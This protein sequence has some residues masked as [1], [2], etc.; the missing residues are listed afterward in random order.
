[1]YIAGRHSG[2]VDYVARI[3][4]HIGSEFGRRWARQDCNLYNNARLID[5]DMVTMG[6]AFE[7]LMT[8]HP[9]NDM[10]LMPL[11]LLLNDVHAR[12]T[13]QRA[14]IRMLCDPVDNPNQLL[15]P[16]Y[17]SHFETVINSMTAR[18]MH[19][20][21]YV[22]ELF[23]LSV[24]THLRLSFPAIL[25]LALNEAVKASYIAAS[26]IPP[27][28]NYVPGSSSGLKV[29]KPPVPD[30]PLYARSPVIYRDV[31]SRRRTIINNRAAVL[32]IVCSLTT[33]LRRTAKYLY[34]NT[35]A[36]FTGV[37]N[38]GDRVHS[39]SD[40][41]LEST[42]PAPPSDPV[43]SWPD[44]FGG[45]TLPPHTTTV[46]DDPLAQWTIARAIIEALVNT[47]SLGG[48]K[49]SLLNTPLIALTQRLSARSLAL[50]TEPTAADPAKQ[51]YLGRNTVFYLSTHVTADTLAKHHITALADNLALLRELHPGVALD[52]RL[53]RLHDAFKPGG[54][55]AWVPVPLMSIAEWIQDLVGCVVVKAAPKPRPLPGEAQEVGWRSRLAM[56]ERYPHR[57]L[58]EPPWVDEKRVKVE[59]VGWRWLV[60]VTADGKKER[61]LLRPTWAQAVQSVEEEKEKVVVA[62]AEEQMQRGL[63]RPQMVE[64]VR[65]VEVC[66][67]GK[68]GGEG[69]A[70]KGEEERYWGGSDSGEERDWVENY[71]RVERDW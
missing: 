62:E 70:R 24:K 25:V 37:M 66:P 63:L 20:A 14:Q 18:S 64:V 51:K 50:L 65:L 3:A 33:L 4:R 29:R 39:I 16:E 35:D 38:L 26:I 59:E 69:G 30:M 1:M 67:Q 44:F 9:D 47:H 17:V 60:G 36:G 49:K 15:N 55:G 57:N 32:R 19:S 43:T 61:R 34:G 56:A 2:S 21:Q 10:R 68:G 58:V 45:T 53:Q 31:T 46:N 6:R 5:M 28:P 22:K 41:V 7:P 11:I 40:T 12:L 48:D 27:P 71:G 23:E 52:P 42:V 54:D 13:S 8:A